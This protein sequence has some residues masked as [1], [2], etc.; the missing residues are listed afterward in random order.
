MLA[1]VRRDPERL[2][3]VQRLVTDL[4]ASE[5]GLALLPE[6]FDAVWDAIWLVAQEQGS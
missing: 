6:G 5:E 4:R 1:A 2:Q 3:H